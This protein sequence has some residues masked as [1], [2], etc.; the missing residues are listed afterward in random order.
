[1]VSPCGQADPPSLRRQHS[2]TGHPPRKFPR[3]LLQNRSDY[4]T[5]K[6]PLLWMNDQR[7]G[8]AASMTMASSP[9]YFELSKQADP[10]MGLKPEEGHMT[11]QG[12]SRVGFSE[13]GSTPAR[14]NRRGSLILPPFR[15]KR[16][17]ALIGVASLTG[18]SLASCAGSSL[19]ASSTCSQFMSASPQA[20]QT[21]V[22]QLAQQYNKP[23][24]STPLGSPEVPYYCSG[25][26]NVTLGEFFAQ[27]QD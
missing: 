10:S 25:N 9:S 14:T 6:T 22:D 12:S 23:D 8:R 3:H 13:S 17:I 4:S 18:L 7:S 24:Y 1:M 21:A 15:W 26:P 19:S 27:A 2:A 16:S 5:T 20:Q 11:S